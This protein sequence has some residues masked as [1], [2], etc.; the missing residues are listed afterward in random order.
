[1]RDPTL[2]AATASSSPEPSTAERPVETKPVPEEGTDATPRAAVLQASLASHPPA[3]DDVAVTPEQEGGTAT[4]DK[5]P[6]GGSEQPPETPE[7]IRAQQDDSPAALTPA[8]LRPKTR[9]THGYK[10]RPPARPQ[11]PLTF[12]QRLFGHKEPKPAK[13]G[14]PRQ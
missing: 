9:S 3:P 8:P 11:P 2:A 7:V 5:V 6:E 10:A 12:W 1:M 14:K 13:P 4:P